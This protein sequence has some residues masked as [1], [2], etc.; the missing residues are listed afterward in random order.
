MWSR[1]PGLLRSI[2]RREDFLITY[3]S[4]WT[5]PTGWRRPPGPVQPPSE[6]PLT[7]ILAEAGIEVDTGMGKGDFTPK[8]EATPFTRPPRVVFTKDTIDDSG[9]RTTDCIWW[10]IFWKPSTKVLVPDLEVVHALERVVVIPLHTPLHQVL[11]PGARFLRA[12]IE[13]SHP[14]EIVLVIFFQLVSVLPARV[15][16]K[17]FHHLTIAVPH[18]VSRG[19]P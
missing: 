10:K 16:H 6:N 17:V 12:L 13:A 5:T 3:S 14:P 4:P 1:R 8:N 11:R 2:F 15:V 19:T 7:A 9:P 18:E